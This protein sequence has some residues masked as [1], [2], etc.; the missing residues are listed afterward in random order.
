MEPDLET[1]SKRRFRRK[2]TTFLCQEMLYDYVTGRLDNERKTDVEKFLEEDKVSK[3]T[4]KSVQT[5]I[6]YSEKLS[7]ADVSQS[8]LQKLSES[9]NAR[10]AANRVANWKTWPESV[11][12]SLSAL[13]ISIVVAGLVAVIPWQ[14]LPSLNAKDKA[15]EV[16]L[17]DIPVAENIETSGE[18]AA[19]ETEGSGDLEETSGDEHDAPGTHE[20]ADIP[21]L[22]E[23]PVKA[24]AEVQTI[25][26]KPT[27]L[28]PSVNPSVAVAKP[29]D[30][31]AKPPAEPA[32]PSVAA[33]K[34]PVED[35]AQPTDETA[36]S[37]E[38]VTEAPA[39]A[40]AK[41]KKPRG[42]VYRAFMNLP[43]VD[44]VTPEVVEKLK[45]FGAEKA[46]EVELGWRR[47]NGSYFHFTLPES[48]E[49]SAL[50]MLRTYGPVRISKDP[51]P[52]VMPEGQVRF[53]LWLEP[54]Q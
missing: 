8:L 32:K 51:H 42:F 29:T 2:L 46:G 5:G 7:R 52:R 23:P 34:P 38:A 47:G 33:V 3:E 19:D 6:E 1:S 14:K 54:G 40:A 30:I 45:A 48:N 53:I 37:Q 25:K 9:E 15:G 21:T 28:A 35:T 12:W 41:E 24:I 39:A 31:V 36:S 49:E 17:A 22:P 4:L 26:A 50:E 10:T 20:V 44:A 18:P 16:V 13:T 11:R 27:P 43:N